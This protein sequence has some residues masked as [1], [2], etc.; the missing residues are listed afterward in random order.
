MEEPSLKSGEKSMSGMEDDGFSMV[1]MFLRSID[2]VAGIVTILF[3][4]FKIKTNLPM[5]LKN[6]KLFS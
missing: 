2:A 1:S 6:K 4:N 5:H 3:L